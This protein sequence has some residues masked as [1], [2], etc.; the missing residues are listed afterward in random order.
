MLRRRPPAALWALVVLPATA[1]CVHGRAL[2]AGPSGGSTDWPRYLGPDAD[3]KSKET[4]INKDWGA[5]PPKELWRVPLHDRGFAC[6]SVADG[7][8]FI[9]DH[10]GKQDIVLALDLETG[11]EIWRFAYPDA[12]KWSHGYARATPTCDNGRLYTLGR[13]GLLNCLDART[14]KKIWAV[15]YCDDLGGE[16]PAWNY[17]AAPIID[18]S[19]LIVAP[20]GSKGTIA[21]LDKKTGRV[22]WRG[23]GS[24]AISYAT[25]VIATIG[26]KKQ[27]VVFTAKHLEGVDPATGRVIWSVGWDTKW[28]CHSATPIVIGDRVFISSNYARGAAVFAIAGNAARKVWEIKAVHVHFNTPVYHDGYLYCTS[29]SSYSTA[30]PGFHCI[31][32]KTGRVAWEA[33]SF[34]KGGMIAVDGTLIVID[35]KRGDVVMIELSPK[36]YRELGRMKPLGGKSWTPPIIARGKLIIRNTK[37]MACFDL[38]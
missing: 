21:V 6:P 34:E 15:H 38:R 27:Y 11:K 28:D 20:G 35:G 19:R 12:R 14:G 26:G 16:R 31:D 2:A 8:V 5:R 9:V 18:G 4:G 25:P 10:E 22:I 17:A 32:A 1:V 30:K 33:K 7:K 13:M 29:H 37:A 24:D 36:R 23:G 3:G